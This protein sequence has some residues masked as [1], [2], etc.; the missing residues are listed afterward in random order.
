MSGGSEAGGS[1]LRAIIDGIGRV[2]RAPALLA[3]VWARDGSRQ[4]A[5]RDLRCAR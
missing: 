1:P 5:A 4:P 3:G 2:N